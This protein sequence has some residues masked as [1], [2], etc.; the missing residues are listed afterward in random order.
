MLERSNKD[1]RDFLLVG[2]CSFSVWLANLIIQ[3]LRG[4]KNNV[5]PETRGLLFI[6]SSSHQ[7]ESES[8]SSQHNNA[9]MEVV[10]ILKMKY[11]LEERE[12]VSVDMQQ[13]GGKS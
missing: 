9:L 8:N 11:I 5:H 12:S 6:P 4:T 1:L 13:E 7:K 2:A 3:L 10:V